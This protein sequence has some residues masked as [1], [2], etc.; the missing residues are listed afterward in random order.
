MQMQLTGRLIR[1]AAVAGM[2]A[3]TGLSG[4]ARVG[5]TPA[6]TTVMTDPPNDTKFGATP[7]TV[8]DPQIDLL[9]LS[10]ASTGQTLTVIVHVV[11]IDGEVPIDTSKSDRFYDFTAQFGDVA[12]IF[13]T[14]IP[15]GSPWSASFTVSPPDVPVC[16]GLGTT[17]I[18]DTTAD[19]VSATFSI[20]ALNECPAF[21]SSPIHSGSVLSRM[22]A[23]STQ[24][25]PYTALFDTAAP[26]PP[27]SETYTI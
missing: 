12:V 9:D 2:V 10:L 15:P 27:G 17:P 18:V 3:L 14:D 25:T 4:A 23:S 26:P 19:T 1:R 11:D 16:T 7:A 5:A 6:P 22:H 8:E 20:A 21:Q 24:W 13:H